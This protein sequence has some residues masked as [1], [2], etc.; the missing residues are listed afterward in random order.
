MCNHL[1]C[2]A[3]YLETRTVRAVATRFEA[4]FRVFRGGHVA[5]VFDCV[6]DLPRR[7]EAGGRL[8]PDNIRPN[9][10]C[11]DRALG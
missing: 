4:A 5:C 11:A 8:G 7:I 6:F 2:F 9:Q 3:M 1:Y 10:T